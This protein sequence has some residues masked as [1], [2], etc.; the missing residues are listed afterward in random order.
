MAEAS[1]EAA[2]Q[3]GK[4]R[5]RCEDV[6]AELDEIKASQRRIL[7]TLARFS[8]PPSA[9]SAR[10][11]AAGTRSAKLHPHHEETQA[12][13]EVEDSHSHEGEEPPL[14]ESLSALARS[15]ARVAT[16]A[17][18]EGGECNDGEAVVA[19][20]RASGVL[21]PA[22]L[23]KVLLS[24]PPVERS[25]LASFSREVSASFPTPITTDESPT[26]APSSAAESAP[27]EEGMQEQT[28]PP[29]DDEPSFQPM[30]GDLYSEAQVAQY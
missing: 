30:I 4:K 1:G 27:V 10:P 9:G 7:K 19:M 24:L 2:A 5:V 25:L 13:E 6:V 16:W 29:F 23:R 15:L 17:D 28:F 18:V 21:R 22:K 14:R 3:R 20:G 8:S 26:P 12:E 11:P